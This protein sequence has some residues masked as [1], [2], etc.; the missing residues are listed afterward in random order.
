MLRDSVN[1]GRHGLVCLDT[2]SLVP[3]TRAEADEMDTGQA[4]P[5]AVKSAVREY[6]ELQRI[7]DLR[8]AG[9]LLV[10]GTMPR[11]RTP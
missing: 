11:L 8:G 4:V 10:R 3:P 2:A 6:P 7:L 5:E 9:W 1:Q